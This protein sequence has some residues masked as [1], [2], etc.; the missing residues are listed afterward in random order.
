MYYL[1]CNVS[2]ISKNKNKIYLQC[3]VYV[4]SFVTNFQQLLNR[5]ANKTRIILKNEELAILQL[6]INDAFAVN[7]VKSFVT[8]T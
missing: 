3:I 7:S 8:A 5:S 1:A 4:F 2:M 6:P